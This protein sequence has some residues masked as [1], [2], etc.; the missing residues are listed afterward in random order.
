MSPFSFTKKHF[1]EK[2]LR[3]RFNLCRIFNLA[4]SVEHLAQYNQRSQR[5]DSRIQKT[6][7]Q[8]E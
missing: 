4:Y 8:S 6:T 3:V 1:F 2:A 5:D 7:K